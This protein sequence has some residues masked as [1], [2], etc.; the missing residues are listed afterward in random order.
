MTGECASVDNRP[1]S[2]HTTRR[3]RLPI[4][5]FERIAI[6]FLAVLLVTTAVVAPAATSFGVRAVP[7]PAPILLSPGGKSHADTYVLQGKVD[8]VRPDSWVR[9]LRNGLPIDSVSVATD[10]L[11]S[12]R[13]PLLVGDNSLRA[14][15]YLGTSVSPGSNIV[16]VHFDDRPGFF[17]PVPF[18]PG[19]SFDLNPVVTAAKA[20]LR[21]FDTQ[22]A[23]VVRFE[24]RE[25][26]TFYSFPWDGK[27]ASFQ[28]V[29]RGPLVA[30][31]TIDYPDGTHDVIRQVFLFDPEGSR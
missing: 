25:P 30:V 1:Q 11:F 26:R 9:I 3:K 8:L 24:N 14:V 7:L 4:P 15:L 19:A 16:N 17:M 27:N 21:V 28:N 23:L 12:K 5:T 18:V 20:E 31:A 2:L 29:L 22:G 13:V 6:R 10:V